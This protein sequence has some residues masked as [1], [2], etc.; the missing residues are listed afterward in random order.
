MTHFRSWI[1]LAA[2]VAV[3]A[4]GNDAAAPAQ[5]DASTTFWRVRFDAH[6]VTIS[7]G[8][9]AYQTFQAHATALAANGAPLDASTPVVYATA[10]SNV[11]VTQ[12]GLITAKFATVGTV[13]VVTASLSWQNVTLRDTLYVRVTDTAATVPFAALSIQPVAGDSAKTAVYNFFG[14]PLQAHATNAAGDS[15]PD[16]LVHYSSSNPTVAQVVGLTGGIDVRTPGFTTFYAQS[17]VYGVSRTDSV[18][19]QVTNPADVT[20]YF[21]ADQT[22]ALAFNPTSTLIT[23]GGVVNFNT[24]TDTLDVIFD[25][26]SA[27]EASMANPTYPPEYLA[28][29]PAT[30]SGN[31]APFAYDPA[32]PSPGTR[33]RRF[34]QI[35]IYPYHSART[36]AAGRIIVR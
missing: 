4:C 30:G 1:L 20:I 2:S 14:K 21:G 19:Y 32:D 8:V 29:Y 11:T 13:A 31:I 3:T 24:Y 10:D 27:A 18:V 15:L 23:A 17:V 25:D 33:A 7:A 6:A 9:P 12:S 35:G 16:V 26:P 34:S 28:T 22:G 36:G 5:S